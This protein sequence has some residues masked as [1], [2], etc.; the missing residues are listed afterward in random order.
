MRES[1]TNPRNNPTSGQPALPLKSI[2]KKVGNTSPN[3]M[4]YDSE[5]ETLTSKKVSR[6]GVY[7]VRNLC[8]PGVRMVPMKPPAFNLHWQLLP[9]DRTRS[10]RLIRFD[11]ALPVEDIRFEGESYRIK[12]SDAD[13]DKPAVDGGLT[14][15]QIDFESGPFE[16]EVHVKNSKG[17]TCRDVFDAI[18][19]TFNEQLTPYERKQIPPHQRQ[20][21]QAAFRLRCKVKPCLAEVEFR[22]GLKRVDVLQQGTIFLGLTQPK[23]GSDWI[24]NLGKWPYGS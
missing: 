7:D 3:R 9:Y 2:L 15:M 4:G 21:V 16:W 8:V 6:S 19:E 14:K 17:I 22:Q 24:L 1:T 12:V 11:V 18:Y 20:E 10:R 23:S 13:L 5:G